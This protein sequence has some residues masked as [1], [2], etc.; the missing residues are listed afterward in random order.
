MP[1]KRSRNW[2]EPAIPPPAAAISP[3]GLLRRLGALFYDLIL[4]VGILFAATALLLPLRAGEAFRPGQA[5]YSTY[6][7]AVS[8][9]FFGWFW[10]HGGQT[11]GMRAWKIRLCAEGGGPVNWRQAGLRFLAAWLSLLPFGLGFLWALLDK[12]KRC[13][14]DRIA[15]T[16]MVRI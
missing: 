2:P 9:L 5:A 8:F 6:L 3:P 14:H 16:R 7:L 4:L 11:L 1:K 10:T 15:R 13:W 12:E